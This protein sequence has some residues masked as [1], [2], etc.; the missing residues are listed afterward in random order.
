[1]S[2]TL[3]ALQNRAAAI[4]ARMK[5]LSDIAD[6]SEEQG[7]ELKSLVKES[8]E[9][10]QN[11]EFEANIAKEEAQLRAV[12]EPAAPA[13]APAPAPAAGTAQPAP[14]SEEIGRAHV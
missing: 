14:E 6:R 8:V 2:K 1:M 7:A 13:S 5:A 9:V 3:K 11:L 10:R 12:V 4:S